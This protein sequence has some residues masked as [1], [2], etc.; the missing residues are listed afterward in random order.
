MG[1][2]L[3]EAN[4]QKSAGSGVARVDCNLISKYYELW[5]QSPPFDLGMTIGSALRS[6]GKSIVS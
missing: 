2:A 3:L 6:N 1:Y 5:M 4:D